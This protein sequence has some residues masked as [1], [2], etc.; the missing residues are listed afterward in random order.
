MVCPGDVTV[1]EVVFWAPLFLAW[2]R[3]LW[4]TTADESRLFLKCFI[5]ITPFTTIH[6]GFLRRE[7]TNTVHTNKL[8]F[9]LRQV[10][11]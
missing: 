9:L 11:G 1:V 10:Q 8:A 4:P 6:A 2:V 7:W 3:R 5:A